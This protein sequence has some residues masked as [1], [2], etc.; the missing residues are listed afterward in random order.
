MMKD[1]QLVQA[2][3]GKLLQAVGPVRFVLASFFR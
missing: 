1:E 2:A 3:K